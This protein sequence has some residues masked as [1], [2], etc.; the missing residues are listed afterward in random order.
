M[1]PS[2][3]A[4]AISELGEGGRGDRALKQDTSFDQAEAL[5]QIGIVLPSVASSP[6]RP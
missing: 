6:S 3:A 1:E 2:E 4:E 5:F